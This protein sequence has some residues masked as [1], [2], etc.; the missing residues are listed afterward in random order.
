MRQL[1]FGPRRY[2]NND[3]PTFRKSVQKKPSHVTKAEQEGL[4]RKFVY[5]ERLEGPAQIVLRCYEFETKSPEDNYIRTAA[6]GNVYLPFLGAVNV[7]GTAKSR[8]SIGEREFGRLAS[9]VDHQCAFFRNFV[10]L[11]KSWHYRA[12]HNYI[13]TK[14]TIER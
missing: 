5:Y 11:Q 7:T 9:A 6:F 8:R 14:E 13:A 4:K 12:L 10:R 1:T 2:L 3:R